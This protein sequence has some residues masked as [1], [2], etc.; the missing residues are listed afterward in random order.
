MAF[1]NFSIA[2]FLFNLVLVPGPTIGIVAGFWTILRDAGNTQAG[3]TLYAVGDLI[4]GICS[5]LL[6]IITLNGWVQSSNYK[7]SLLAH[8]YGSP[9]AESYLSIVMFLDFIF[10][11]IVFLADVIGL[12][13]YLAVHPAASMA[14]LCCPGGL[15]VL[16]V[17]YLAAATEGW[18]IL[19]VLQG[20]PPPPG[21]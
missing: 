16:V 13:G 8:Q 1:S 18:L 15:N 19:L 20:A 21:S 14:M 9:T 10:L 3:K 12:I 4:R 6:V 5:F 17:V 2:L 7:S 11:F